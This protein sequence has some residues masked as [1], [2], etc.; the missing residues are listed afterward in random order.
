MS[1]PCRRNCKRIRQR[2]LHTPCKKRRFAET[3]LAQA[4]AWA[5]AKAKMTPEDSPCIDAKELRAAEVASNNTITLY[6]HSMGM[7]DALVATTASD[8]D[9][10]WLREPKPMFAKLRSKMQRVRDCT[11]LN[12][13]CSTIRWPRRSGS[14][15]RQSTSIQ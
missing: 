5:K 1:G 10:E 13:L 4:K 8:A 14:C 12:A 11:S 9:W 15:P 6:R 3:A 2:R 7:A